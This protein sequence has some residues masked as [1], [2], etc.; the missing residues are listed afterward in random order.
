MKTISLQKQNQERNRIL[1]RQVACYEHLSQLPCPQNQLQ[2]KETTL[3]NSLR[4]VQLLSHVQPFVIPWTAACQASLSITNSRS[5]LKVMSIESMMPS[6]H[7]SLCG[8]L[9][10]PPSVL[11]SIRV[12]S[13]E[14][15]L[16][17][18][19]PKYWSFTFSISPSIEYSWLISFRMD[20]LDLLIVQGTLKNLR[21]HHSSKASILQHSVFFIVQLSQPYMTSG[22]T[23]ALTRQIFVVKVMSLL[24]NILSTLVIVFF[25]GTNTF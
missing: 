5:L 21:Q 17:M 23:I 19:W 4:S 10:L 18:R 15:V 13:D 12:F 25:Q 1:M 3:Q 16:L 8:P 14:S 2:E 24:F 9:L 7:L 6:N 22:K 11:P 20:W